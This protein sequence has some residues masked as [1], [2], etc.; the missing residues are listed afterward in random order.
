[1]EGGRTHLEDIVLHPW[2]AFENIYGGAACNSPECP[3]SDTTVS[4]T[5]RHVSWDGLMMVEKWRRMSSKEGGGTYRDLRLL[6]G[7][8]AR[9]SCGRS[10]YDC[11]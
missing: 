3:G 4:A 8:P 9:F 5:S 2:Y 1:M 6:R 10:L 7:Y 11:C